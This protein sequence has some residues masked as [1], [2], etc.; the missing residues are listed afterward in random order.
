MLFTEKGC[1]ACHGALAE[2][3]FGPRIAGTALSFD[4]VLQQVRRPRDVMIPFSPE[5]LSDDGVHD[6]Y[7]YL[8]SLDQ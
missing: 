3:G 4:Q 7:A 6:I 5:E 1:V 8:R 2:G